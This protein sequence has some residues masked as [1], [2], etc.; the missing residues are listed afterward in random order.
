MSARVVCIARV[1]GSGGE[2]VGRQ[3]ADL[4]GFELIDE[5]IIQRA[6]ETENIDANELGEVEQR[7][8][9]LGRLTRLL[10]SSGGVDY[11]WAPAPALLPTDPKSL[12][13]LIIRSIHETADQGNV[14]IV[15]HAASYALAERSGILRVLVTAPTSVRVARVQIAAGGIEAKK[16]EKVISDDDTARAHYL[17]AFYDVSQEQPTDYDLVLNSETIT[18][19]SLAHI[20]AEAARV[21]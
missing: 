8:S 18:P 3:V 17:K 15:S 7:R 19:E 10:A 20:V 12:R 21:H 6:A 5:E 14:V 13:S 1:E 9:V 16:A 2:A 4:L 11:A